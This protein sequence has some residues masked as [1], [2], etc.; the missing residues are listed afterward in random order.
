MVM[1]LIKVETGLEDF[2]IMLDMLVGWQRIYMLYTVC[3]STCFILCASHHAW[4]K[5]FG[6]FETESNKKNK[7]EQLKFLY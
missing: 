6:W 1:K 5:A 3:K 2:A 4:G 7:T